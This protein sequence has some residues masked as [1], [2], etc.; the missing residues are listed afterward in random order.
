MKIVLAT[1]HSRYVHASLALPSLAATVAGIPGIE[2]VIR[3]STLAEPP[4]RILRKLEAEEADLYA[5]SCYIWNVEATLKIAADLKKV[6]PSAL[7]VLGGPEVSYG[8]FE[9][10]ERNPAIDVIVRGEGESTFRELAVAAA[11]GEPDLAAIDGLVYRDG[12]RIESTPEREAMAELDLLPS[13]F[14]AGLVDFSKPLI[15][16]E[17]SRGCPFSCAFCMSSLERGVRSYSRERIEND[18]SLLM[19][20]GVG[21]VKL[22]DRTFNFDASRADLIW[23]HILRHN[24]SS[25]FHFEIAAD[26]LTEENI[27]LLRR[28]PADTF[29]FEIGVQSAAPETL[30]KVGRKSDLERLL[31]NVRRLREET[32]VTVHLDLVAG[33]P[34]EGLEGFYDSLAS[35]LETKPHHIQVEP[36]KVLK[37]APMRRIAREEGYLFSETPPY[38]VLQTP[39]LGYREIGTVETAARLLDL[40]WNSGRFATVLRVLAE[41]KPL[42]ELFRELTDFWESREEEAPYPLPRLFDALWEF[43]AGD[44]EREEIA[45]ALAYDWCL[46]EYPSPERLPPF[47]LDRPGERCANPEGTAASPGTRV[48]S[49]R[50][51]FLRDFRSDPPGPPAEIVFVYRSAPGKG[52]QVSTPG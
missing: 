48:R 30:R 26:L 34:G 46:M 28:V 16:V 36:L 22:V 50:R 33:L 1:L 37:G 29:R 52:L 8:S 17:T 2:A 12:E 35:L 21:T 10:M 13:P 39:W 43:S 18:L 45:E 3:E 38:A 44:P 31:A 5:F 27:R 23:E 20:R 6:R 24:R 40:F 32:A 19:E 41:R 42:H 51:L 7:V 49:Y 25:R 15:Y 47:F 9:L 14:A 4:G 11:A